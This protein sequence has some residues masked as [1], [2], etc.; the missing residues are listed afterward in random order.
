MNRTLLFILMLVTLSVGVSGVQIGIADTNIGTDEKPVSQP[1]VIIY[2]MTL[3]SDDIAEIGLEDIDDVRYVCVSVQDD[4]TGTELVNQRCKVSVNHTGKF[5]VYKSF[6]DTSKGV[7]T[8]EYVENVFVSHER[9]PGLGVAL[10]IISV[11]MLLTSVFITPYT[12]LLFI[13]TAVGSFTSFAF[14]YKY[15]FEEGMFIGIISVVFLGLLVLI[16]R[17]IR[18]YISG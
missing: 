16:E 13:L 17:I 6:I 14:R 12:W 15:I 8:T 9:V 7:N 3:E 4:G 18:K 10:G 5:S 11:L 2:N 1:L